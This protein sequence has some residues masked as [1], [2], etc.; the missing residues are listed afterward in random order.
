MPLE[1]LLHNIA[2]RT[3][4]LADLEEVQQAVFG[5]SSNVYEDRERCHEFA[6]KMRRA[7]EVLRLR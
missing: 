4:A 1:R 3:A 2:K 7:I 6:E 5:E